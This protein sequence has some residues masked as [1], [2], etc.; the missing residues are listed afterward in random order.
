MKLGKKEADVSL[1]YPETKDLPGSLKENMPSEK[2]KY[3]LTTTRGNQITVKENQSIE[4]ALL[5]TAIKEAKKNKEHDRMVQ[6]NSM[7]QQHAEG[8]QWVEKDSMDLAEYLTGKR[9][10]LTIKPFDK[11]AETSKLTSKELEDVLQGPT[12]WNRTDVRRF[13]ETVPGL[14]DKPV[15]TI[16]I[17]D[18]IHYGHYS[19]TDPKSGAKYDGRV[20]LNSLGLHDQRLSDAGVKD[21][22]TIDFSSAAEKG[23]NKVPAVRSGGTNYDKADFAETKSMK[24]EKWSGSKT[25][26]DLVKLIDNLNKA[27]QKNAIDRRGR[28]RS[29]KAA[30]SFSHSKRKPG[31]EHISLTDKTINDPAHYVSTL[32]HELAHAIEWQVT[33]FTGKKTYEMLGATSKEDKAKL[34]AELKAIVDNLESEAV[35]SSDPSYYYGA[36]EMWASLPVPLHGMPKSSAG[37]KLAGLLN[38]SASL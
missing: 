2:I 27:G 14:K 8:K 34:K 20:K 7:K 30:G 1:V 6:F 26:E 31:D 28:L 9:E 38:L 17:E 35:V 21:G 32:A 4:N 12:S 24:R 22:M 10:K 3:E 33:G 5:T 15:L 29:K 19:T 23:S 37:L 11:Q 18:G 13:V 36:T 16:K 25:P